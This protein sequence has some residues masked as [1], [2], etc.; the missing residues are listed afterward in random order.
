MIEAIFAGF[1]NIHIEAQTNGFSY[2][3]QGIRVSYM[4]CDG[5]LV[6]LLSLKFY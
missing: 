4:D 2:F 1:Q 5:L 3:E 6:I